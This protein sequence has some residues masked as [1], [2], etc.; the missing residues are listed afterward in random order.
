[1][2]AY[3]HPIYEIQAESAAM[4][5]CTLWVAKKSKAEHI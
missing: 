4:L 3:P 2:F 1:M 5:I